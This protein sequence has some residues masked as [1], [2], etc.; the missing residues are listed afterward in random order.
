MTKEEIEKLKDSD[1]DVRRR[2]ASNPSTPVD[3]LL[4]L[5][6]DSDCDVRRRVASNPS[7]P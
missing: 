4:E 6:K 1:C 3:A 2:V 5:S 7:T